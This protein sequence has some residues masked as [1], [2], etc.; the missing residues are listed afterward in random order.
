MMFVGKQR[1]KGLEF[2]T[3]E[4]CN[5]GT[6]HADLVASLLGRTFPD[7]DSQQGQNDVKKLLSAVSNNIPGLLEE[8]YVGKAGQKIARRN[9]PK[10]PDGAAVLRADGSLVA[11]HMRIFAAKMGYALHYQAFGKPVPPEGA[12]QPLWFSN[13]QA[14]RGELPMSAIELLPKKQTLRQGTKEVGDQFEYSWRVTDEGRHGV[15]YCVFR[16][17][18]AV[19]AVTALDRSELLEGNADRFPLVIPGDFRRLR[20]T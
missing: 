13:T 5:H 2:P 16:S 14:A 15:F 9:I 4:P 3:C 18:F 8:M 20:P 7:P 17:S 11:R 12:V 10:M 6:S 19:F 1:P